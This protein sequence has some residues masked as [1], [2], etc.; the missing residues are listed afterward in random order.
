[1]KRLVRASAASL[2]MAVALTSM[3]HAQCPDGTPPPCRTASAAVVRPAAA[4]AV[5][6]R[7]WIVLPFANVTRE[8]AVDWMREASVNLLYLDLSRWEDVRVIDDGRVADLVLTLPEA[9]RGT[10]ALT[11]GLT[12]ARRAGA[13]RLVMG[14]LLASGART[15]VVAKVYDVTNGRRLRTVQQDIAVRDSMMPAYARL[16]AQVLDVA[17]P[18]GGGSTRD[19][20][21]TRSLDAYQAYMA[22]YQALKGWRL[23]EARR[24]FERAIEL[25]SMFALAHFRLSNTIGWQSGAGDSLIAAHADAAARFATGLPVRERA[26]I[27][28]QQQFAARRF[29]DACDTYRTLL[30]TDP[31]DV[32]AWYQLG[33]CSFHGGSVVPAAP[34]TSAAT[35]TRD[36]T[37]AYR[38]FMRTLELDPSQ[39]LA[40][41][42][43]IDMLRASQTGW[44]IGTRCRFRFTIQILLRGD[45]V[46]AL[47]EPDRAR[48]GLPRDSLA[49]PRR[50]ELLRAAQAI[51]QRWLAAAPDQAEAHFQYALVLLGLRRYGEAVQEIAAA[52]RLGHRQ[53]PFLVHLDALL[54]SDS[55]GTRRIPEAARLAD[56]V[57]G[58]QVV[59]PRHVRMSDA[60]YAMTRGFMGVAIAGTFG[61][62]AQI[63]ENLPVPAGPAPP[64]GI[65]RVVALLSA[66]VEPPNMAA[67]V[68]TIAALPA[69]MAPGARRSI[70]IL[71][72]RVCTTPPFPTDSA[73]GAS[74]FGALHAG[75]TARARVLTSAAESVLAYRESVNGVG[76]LWGTDVLEVAMARLGLGDTTAALTHL[77]LLE[78]LR[79]NETLQMY[80]LNI[81]TVWLMGRAWLLTGD[82][83]TARGR[84]ED[85]QLYYRRVADL[86][87]GGDPALLP[88]VQRARS[89]I[90]EFMR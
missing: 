57:L 3:A 68:A 48:R 23:D 70:S 44:C 55:L 26:M 40:Y 56:S 30:A 54:L 47:V 64:P 78:R 85:A 76:S 22:G 18:A 10:L 36:L 16:A 84:A 66:G 60:D 88:M 46:V 34:D 35:S 75:D 15:T 69:P 90:P 37:T 14:D 19:V 51:A 50:Q 9:Q 82:L 49:E 13:G 6:P 65:F 61:R 62:V 17:S 2:A 42:H 5:D 12:L 43:L 28:G 41:E 45:S 80:G 27:R 31:G 73:F 8:P 24:L 59:L 1:M 52:R 4:R 71:C 25:D 89:R 77:A 39:H 81:G 58:G 7:T 38:A 20:V 63:P 74:P 32:D 79:T 72:Q 83:L 11:S 53:G 29:A 86:W 33:E 67:S 87:A 21:G